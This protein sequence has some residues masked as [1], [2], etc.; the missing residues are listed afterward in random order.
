MKL[1]EQYKCK[2]WPYDR[3]SHLVPYTHINM[4]KSFNNLLWLCF[5]HLILPATFKWT[6]KHQSK[7]NYRIIIVLFIRDLSKCWP[8]HI[9]SIFKR[10]TVNEKKTPFCFFFMWSPFLWFLFCIYQW[11]VS[12]I[13]LSLV[14]SNTNK[15]VFILL[16]TLVVT[17]LLYKSCLLYLLFFC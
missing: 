13:T 6:G 17:R 1:F 10:L 5:N 15:V 7:Q 2:C 11:S 16:V 8:F 14:S 12:A 9:K 3:N 4:C